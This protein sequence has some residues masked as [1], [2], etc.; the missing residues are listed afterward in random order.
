MSVGNTFGENLFLWI[1]LSSKLTKVPGL[2]VGFSL[3]DP[4]T[5]IYL[6]TFPT[7]TLLD[8]TFH[9]FWVTESAFGGTLCT[10]KLPIQFMLTLKLYNARLGSSASCMRSQ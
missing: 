4:H 3:S 9:N 7:T 10:W 2:S 6:F 5:H 1:Q 8:K